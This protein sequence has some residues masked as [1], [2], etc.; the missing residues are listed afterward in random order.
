MA[1]RWASATGNYSFRFFSPE[2]IDQIL[3]EGAKRGRTGSHDAIERILK[4]EP[5]LGRAEL[6]KFMIEQAGLG[7]DEG[8]VFGAPGEGFMRLNVA[9]PRSLLEQSLEQLA[10]AVKGKC[11]SPN[12]A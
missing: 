11:E 5:G 7:L 3:S 10:L 6:K 8:A 1:D 2:Q 9:C 4:H 12:P